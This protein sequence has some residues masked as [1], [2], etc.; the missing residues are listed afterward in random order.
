[1]EYHNL[2]TVDVASSA[3]LNDELAKLP[4]KRIC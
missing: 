2:E 4:L 3:P 1:M